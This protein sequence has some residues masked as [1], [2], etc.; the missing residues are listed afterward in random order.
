MHYL[1]GYIKDILGYIKDILVK[2]ISSDLCHFNAWHFLVEVFTEGNE[3]VKLDA[4]A[5]Y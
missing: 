5:F 1:K 2:L 4:T 3:R